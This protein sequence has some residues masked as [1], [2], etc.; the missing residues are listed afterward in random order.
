MKKTGFTLIELLIVLAI[1]GI[2]VAIAVPAYVGFK[3]KALAGKM[4]QGE[5]LTTKE[6]EKYKKNKE[7]YDKLLAD[8]NKDDRCVEQKTEGKKQQ[9]ATTQASESGL[10]HTKQA[11]VEKKEIEPALPPGIYVAPIEPIGPIK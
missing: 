4:C 3:Q 8:M 9:G 10:V 1:I 5:R 7:I 6:T 2:L 11:V